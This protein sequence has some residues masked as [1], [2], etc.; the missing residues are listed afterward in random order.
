MFGDGC[1]KT[2]FEEVYL[3]F[4]TIYMIILGGDSKAKKI[5]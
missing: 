1:L 5:K 2:H 4:L 3:Y